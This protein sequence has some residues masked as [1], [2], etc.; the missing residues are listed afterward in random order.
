MLVEYSDHEWRMGRTGD[1][2]YLHAVERRSWPGS[3][4]WI[5]TEVPIV[6]A[7]VTR[8]NQTRQPTF[9]RWFVNLR[10][11]AHPEPFLSKQEA[12]AWATAIVKLQLND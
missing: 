4:S 8:N 3:G 2:W 12:V 6:L 7:T 11:T 5:S 1:R 10:G 9:N